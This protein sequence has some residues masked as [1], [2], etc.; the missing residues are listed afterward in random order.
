MH[1]KFVYVLSGGV[2]FDS[3]E[4]AMQELRKRF[5]LLAEACLDPGLNKELAGLIAV[6]YE[7][8]AAVTKYLP[9]QKEGVSNEQ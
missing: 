9:A 7:E 5:D 1:V 8:L 6:W 4:A 3:P 2:E